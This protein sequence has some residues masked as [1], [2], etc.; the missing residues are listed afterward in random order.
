MTNINKSIIIKNFG[1]K[2]NS[3]NY[4]INVL[5]DQNLNEKP[6]V[7]L[8]AGKYNDQYNFVGL[9]DKSKIKLMKA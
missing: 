9:I 1:K 2:G 7:I 8:W 4:A 6:D 3:T 5:Y